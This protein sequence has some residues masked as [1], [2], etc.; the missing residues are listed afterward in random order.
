MKLLYDQETDS[1]YI[2]LAARPS[3]D[4]REIQ[5]GVVVDLLRRLFVLTTISAQ[6]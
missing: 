5:D 3:V 2:D 6:C 1:L 4:S